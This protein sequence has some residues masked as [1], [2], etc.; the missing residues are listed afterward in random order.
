M[1]STW[2]LLEWSKFCFHVLLQVPNPTAI[3]EDKEVGAAE[4][5]KRKR[6]IS[7]TGSPVTRSKAKANKKQKRQKLVVQL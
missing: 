6:S 3:E 5:K 4:A 2:G 1:V 7:V